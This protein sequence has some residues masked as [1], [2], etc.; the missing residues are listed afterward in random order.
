MT[1]TRHDGLGIAGV[2]CG[3]VDDDRLLI[4]VPRAWDWAKQ[5]AT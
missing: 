2:A 4:A 3:D 5:K 1:E